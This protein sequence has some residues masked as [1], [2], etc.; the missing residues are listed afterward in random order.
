MPYQFGVPEEVIKDVQTGK[1]PPSAYSDYLSPIHGKHVIAINN[2]FKI[3]DWFDC[4][5]FGD[6]G[7]YNVYRIP[8]AAIS[9][10]KVTCCARFAN[11]PEKECAG[12]KYLDRDR[13][14]TMG[15]SDNPSKVS[16]NNNSGAAAISLA[17]H[18]GVK[19]IVLL[20]FDMNSSSSRVSHWFGSHHPNNKRPVIPP[21]ARHLK[22]FPMIA[23]DAAKRGIEILN[24]SNHSSIT[25]FPVVQLHEVL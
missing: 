8:V 11:K 9:Y 2:A 1:Q 25:E 10:L 12:I 5:F 14:K 13:N 23:A 7:W 6:C 15:I 16:W 18:F 17:A 21:Y 19:R 22:G 4:L 20:G 3:G 24:C